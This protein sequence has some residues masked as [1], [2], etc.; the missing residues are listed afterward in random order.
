MDGSPF[1]N[2]QEGCV[3]YTYNFQL[4][5]YDLSEV[6][7]ALHCHLCRAVLQR[8]FITLNQHHCHVTLMLIVTWLEERSSV[9]YNNNGH[10]S[11]AAQSRHSSSHLIARS[12][13]TA[14]ISESAGL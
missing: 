10:V 12:A 14:Q 3:L 13:L 1:I 4:V 5:N 7:I 8:M 9:I 6:N 2:T 11:I